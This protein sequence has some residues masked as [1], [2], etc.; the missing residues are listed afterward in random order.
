MVRR[1][2]SNL[3]QGMSLIISMSAG[4][5]RIEMCRI[6]THDRRLDPE[7]A[8]HGELTVGHRN[9]EIC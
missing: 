6:F 3:L 9:A 7:L 4:Q 5:D 8:T 1:D 2:S